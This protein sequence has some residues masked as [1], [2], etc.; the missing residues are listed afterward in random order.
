[1]SGRSP[2]SIRDDVARLVGADRVV[3]DPTRIARAR[4][5]SWVI[6][7]WRSLWGVRPSGSGT[8]SADVS[9]SL[10]RAIALS[11]TR[12][13]MLACLSS[14]AAVVRNTKVIGTSATTDS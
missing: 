6:A 3:D 10:A 4:R 5:D 8:S 2:A 9:V 14:V 13:R 11:S 12:R 7:V 1:M